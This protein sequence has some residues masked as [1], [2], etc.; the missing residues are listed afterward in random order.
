MPESNTDEARDSLLA[1]AAVAWREDPSLG[2]G[3]FGDDA[4]AT[5]PG[6]PSGYLRAYYWRV[7]TEDLAPP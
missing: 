6:E 4:G 1:L 3:I 2:A 7:A 5:D